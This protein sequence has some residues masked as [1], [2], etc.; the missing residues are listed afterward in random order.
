VEFVA[1]DQVEKAGWFQKQE[2]LALELMVLVFIVY[3]R[4]SLCRIYVFL[5]SGTTSKTPQ[6]VY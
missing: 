5:V 3:I 4:Y 2:I 1:K 6:M